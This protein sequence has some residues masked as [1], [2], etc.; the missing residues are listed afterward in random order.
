MQKGRI[1]LLFLFVSTSL[2]TIL[3]F[4]AAT[5]V[6]SEKNT[7]HIQ[8]VPETPIPTITETPTP[9]LTPTSTSTP[10]PTV[11]P[12]TIPKPIIT[13]IPIQHSSGGMS[14]LLSQVNEYRK[15]QGLSPVSSNSE[16]CSFAK[17]RAQ[18]ISTDFSHT[19]FNNRVNAHSLPYTYHEV[20]ENI[21]MNSNQNDVVAEWIKSPGHAENMR[22]NTP[23]VC[24]EKFGEYYAYEGLR[25]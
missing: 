20:T 8:S 1:L 16:T 12:T 5:Y 22:K 6:F 3:F 9:T 2:L 24:I 11:T 7:S 15:S 13:K 23:Y 19:G 17:T 25:P 21:A 18:E 10:T 14:D 4:T